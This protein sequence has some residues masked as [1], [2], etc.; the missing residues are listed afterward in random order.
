MDSSST[1]TTTK[2][3]PRKA[4]RSRALFATPPGAQIETGIFPGA[5]DTLFLWLRQLDSGSTVETSTGAYAD[6]LGAPA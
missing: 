6:V 4:E 5:V 2:T 1:H 3:S